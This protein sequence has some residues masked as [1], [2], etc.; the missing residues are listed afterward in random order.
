[1]SK[2]EDVKKILDKHF[3][4]SI[5]YAD[6]ER[7]FDLNKFALKICQ[8]FEPK[9]DNSLARIWNESGIEG[10]ATGANKP[11]DTLNEQDIIPVPDTKEEREA[12]GW[13]RIDDKVLIEEGKVV[14]CQLCGQSFDGEGARL[15]KRDTGH[16]KWRLLLPDDDS[17]LLTDEEIDDL[18]PTKDE[19]DAYLGEPDDNI[20]ASLDPQTKRTV[21]RIILYTNKVAQAQDAK[22]AS[23]MEAE[24]RGRVEEIFEEMESYCDRQIEHSQAMLTKLPPNGV[25]AQIEQAG[26]VTLERVKVRLQALKEEIR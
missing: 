11:D 7:T 20:A 24:C 10:I 9:P 13:Y 1:M 14:Q 17:R 18:S 19:I 4:E 16:D 2:N 5:K 15:H 3:E 21:A 26:I 25:Y 22:T 6:V 8:V 23:I 12:L